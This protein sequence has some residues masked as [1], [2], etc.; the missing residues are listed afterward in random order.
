MAELGVRMDPTETSPWQVDIGVT[1]HAGKHK[2]IGGAVSVAY[3]F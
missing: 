2:G 3:M 1:G